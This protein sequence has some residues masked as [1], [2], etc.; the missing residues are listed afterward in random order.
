[1][2]RSCDFIWKLT[3]LYRSLHGRENRILQFSSTLRGGKQAIAALPPFP[4]AVKLI[5]QFSSALRGGKL[6]TEALPLL[7]SAV[8]LIFHLSSAARGGKLETAALPLLPSAV[9]L[10]LYF[11]SAL[12]GGKLETA[13]LRLLPTAVKWIFRF[14]S[15][16]RGGKLEIA[17]TPRV[18]M[19]EIYQSDF[20]SFFHFFCF[21]VGHGSRL[22]SKKW[23]MDMYVWNTIRWNSIQS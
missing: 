5:F 6:E 14:S 21:L 1:M 19:A 18:R 3:Q 11:S 9:M 4:S 17:D 23:R 15:A 10:I 22:S 16:P 7:P 12:R 20:L 13:A 2:E 8:K